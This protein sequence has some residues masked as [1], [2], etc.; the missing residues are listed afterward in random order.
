MTAQAFDQVAT[1]Y[2]VDENQKL[3]GGSVIEHLFPVVDDFAVSENP[4]VVIAYIDITENAAAVR[5]DSD[6]VNGFG[7]TDY[8]NLLK[9]DGQW[10]IVN[11]IFYTHY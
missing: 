5:V 7:F 6:D 3:A 4:R 8:F 10:A 1:I 2:N 11:K 9:I